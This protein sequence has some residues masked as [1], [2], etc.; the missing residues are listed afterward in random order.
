M[1]YNVACVYALRGNAAKGAEWL[2]KTVSTGMPSYTLFSRDS[3]LDPI[4]RDP[5]FVAFINELRP[6]WEVLRDEFGR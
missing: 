5:A 2:E 1:T 4:R 3:H 6:R